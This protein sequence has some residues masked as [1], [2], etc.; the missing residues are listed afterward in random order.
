MAGC[1]SYGAAGTIRTGSPARAADQV[2]VS[3][4]AADVVRRTRTREPSPWGYEWGM[5]TNWSDDAGT[6]AEYAL[7]V[8]GIAAV[9]VIV[10]YALGAGSQRMF[11]QGCQAYP[12]GSEPVCHS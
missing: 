12:H 6:A 4:W 2:V 10:I 7:R 8:A 1:P 9:V 3:D 5:R 11:E